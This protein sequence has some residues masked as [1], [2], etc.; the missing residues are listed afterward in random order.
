VG[1]FTSP[2]SP[3][4]LILSA[5]D[6]LVAS[7]SDGGLAPGA[8]HVILLGESAG[9]NL[10]VSDIIAMGNHA[11]A[12]AFAD[13]R[14]AGTVVIGQ[15]SSL[16]ATTINGGGVDPAGAFT[17]LGSGIAPSLLF[18]GS[19]VLI[20]DDV[21]SDPNILGSVG[22]PLK[23]AVLIGSRVAKTGWLQNIGGTSGYTGLTAIG[24]NAASLSGAGAIGNQALWTG[25]VVLGNLACSNI[26]GE[27][28]ACTFANTVFIG[29]QAGMSGGAA[30]RGNFAGTV[31]VGGLAGQSN[32]DFNLCTIVGFSAVSGTRNANIIAIGAMCGATAPT[33]GNQILIGASINAAGTIATASRNIMIGNGANPAAAVYTNKFIVEMNDS[34]IARQCIFFGDMTT[35]CLTIGVSTDAVDRDM[36]GT[37]LLKLINGTSTGAAPSGGGFFQVIAGELF[38]TASSNV[39]TQL[40][41]GTSFTVATLPGGAFQGQRAYVN[42][43][44]APAFAAIVAGGGAVF[45]PVYFDGAAWRCG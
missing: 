32:Q 13:V 41:Q 24:Y 28:S 42:N 36:P 38:W 35:G 22:N 37:N 21:A 10:S 40:S 16:G 31:V 29:N 27:T 3:P 33:G 39:R 23:Q 19:S 44:L 30:G 2:P 12:G 20:G 11:L 34:V 7:N 45:T 43:A 17:A 14:L 4:S 26:T 6:R 5:T 18:G 8:S 25:A 9:A 1:Q 15:R